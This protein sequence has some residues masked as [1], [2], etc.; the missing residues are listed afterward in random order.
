MRLRF[1]RVI[2]AVAAMLVAWAGEG[3]TA[4]EVAIVE[5]ALPG[6]GQRP[7]AMVVAPDG[8]LWVT[9]VLKHQIFRI[10][11]SGAI[12]PFRVPG[13]AVGV[14]QGIAFGPDGHIWFTSREENAIRRMS[15]T[16]EFN[17]TFVIPSQ[18]TKPTQLNKGSWPRG[19]TVG[20]DGHLWFAEMAANKIGRITVNGEFTEFTI[21]TEDA[22][23]YGV[24]TGPDRNLW[25]TES[26]AGKIGRLDVATGKITEFALSSP[27][28]RPRDITVGPDGHLWFSMNGT[29]RIG[30]IS[31]QGEMT[32]FPLPADT[33]P[34]GIA[35][36]GDGNVWFTAFKPNK[37]GRITPAGFVTLFDL[38]TANAQPFGMTAG[39]NGVVWFS[40]QANHIGRIALA[41][42]PAQ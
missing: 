7:Q 2:A 24:V 25:F 31:M 11:P 27:Q 8:N 42:K 28:A 30:R 18:A 34:I 41:A 21:P 35:A 12:T 29:D 15:V 3:V 19:I 5:T 14:L 39:R 9:E 32:E 26:G 22:Q 10:E 6:E 16:G 13:E 20:P 23:A 36:G 17:G 33:K 38:K 4:D 1:F 40:S 37:I